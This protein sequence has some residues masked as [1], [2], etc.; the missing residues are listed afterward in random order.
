MKNKEELHMNYV[1]SSSLLFGNQTASL[2][3]TSPPLFETIFIGVPHPSICALDSGQESV[4]EQSAA[5]K[6]Q[7]KIFHVKRKKEEIYICKYVINIR[8][9]I[10]FNSIKN[11][12]NSYSCYY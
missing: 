11:R 10:I 9:I 8:N 1:F 6:S 7:E 2:R 5:W 3:V 12:S 4:A